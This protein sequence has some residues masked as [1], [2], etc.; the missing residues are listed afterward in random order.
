MHEIPL[1][2]DKHI[3]IENY[4]QIRVYKRIFV[5]VNYWAVREK[6]LSSTCLILIDKVTDISTNHREVLEL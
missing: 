1:Y 4:I 3:S 5:P 2:I 6:I